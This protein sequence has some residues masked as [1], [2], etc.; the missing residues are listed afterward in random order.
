MY[1]IGLGSYALGITAT[2]IDGVR[3]VFATTVNDVW[4]IT[5]DGTQLKDA[6]KVWTQVFCTIHD[7]RVV[8]ESCF[9][10]IIS[11]DETDADCG[12]SICEKCADEKICLENSDC[13]SDYCNPDGKCCKYFSSNRIA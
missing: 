7:V 9:D 5:D 8:E 13:V 1:Y 6:T 10:A 4:R 11:Q 2:D 12:G 3:T